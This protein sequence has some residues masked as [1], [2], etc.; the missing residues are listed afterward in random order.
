MPI[1]QLKSKN[2]STSEIPKSWRNGA[3]SKKSFGARL[4]VNRKRLLALA[5]ILI[6][7][8]ALIALYRYY[9]D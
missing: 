7:F 3:S 1:P 6:A 9:L 5:T 4:W 2:I 8:G